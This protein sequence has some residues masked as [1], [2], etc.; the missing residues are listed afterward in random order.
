MK[1]VNVS[2][3][4]YNNDLEML[5]AAL[6]SVFSESE[7][8]NKCYIVDNSPDEKLATLR[9][10]FPV[11]YIFT[12]R[13]LGFGSAHNIAIKES[14]RDNVPFH[15]VLN[16]DVYFNAGVIRSLISYMEAHSTCGLVM[17]KVLYP[18]GSPQALCKLLPSP[19]TLFLRRF[20]SKK[21]ASIMFPKYEIPYHAIASSS[22]V[23]NLSGC[24][25]FFKT[26]ALAK[27]EGFDENF[28]MYLEDTD[29]CRRVSNYYETNI[30]SEVSIFH[31][32][33]KGSYVNKTLLK[34]HV[35]SAIYYF[36]KWGW[37]IDPGRRSKNLRFKK[38]QT[39][40]ARKH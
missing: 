2:L 23:P 7:L 1:S 38:L 3:V 22:Y 14:I 30:Y 26:N 17:P 11:T 31:H 36:N 24:F 27:V 10:E 18:D 40:N 32:Y 13:N 29:I 19:S 9:N 37:F 15:V 21:I 33:G 4:T 34:Y 20:F 6:S 8:I 35:E 39:F 25:M 16:P 12:G 5:R 28:F